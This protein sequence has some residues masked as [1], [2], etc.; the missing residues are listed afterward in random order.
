MEGALDGTPDKKFGRRDISTILLAASFI[1]YL[2]PDELK[3]FG[4]RGKDP[5]ETARRR[6]YVYGG[7]AEGCSLHGIRQGYGPLAR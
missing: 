2:L 7:V 3:P 6:A 4:W 5:D 1:P